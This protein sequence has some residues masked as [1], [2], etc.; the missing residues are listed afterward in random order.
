MTTDLP[1]LARKIGATGDALSGAALKRALAKGGKVGKDAAFDVARDVAGGDRAIIMGGRR[2]AFL[3]AGYDVEQT[4][5]A[6]NL[7]PPGLWVLFEKGAKEHQIPGRRK[8]NARILA[9]ADGSYAT[10]VVHPG[11]GGVGAIRRASGSIRP[12]ASAAISRE[13]IEEIGRAWR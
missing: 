3:G 9:L 1:G 8:R 10:T 13:M 5:V 11:R 12:K 4:S 7:R 2:K 6:I